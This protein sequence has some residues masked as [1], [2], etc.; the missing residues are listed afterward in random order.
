MT[1]TADVLIIG[2]GVHGAS[3]AFHLAGRGLRACILERR[4]PAAGA[5]GRSSGLVR[6]H[7]DLEPETRLAWESFQY[8]RDWDVRVGGECGFTRT[9][10]LHIPRPR[11]VEQMKAN[12]AMHQR[13]GIPSLVVNAD[14]V[15]RLAPSFYVDD[16]LAAAYEPESGHADPY[17]TTSS[18]LAAARA[19]GATL[20]QDCEV[21]GIL[22]EGG[23]V[24]GAQTT[25]GKFHAPVVVNAAGPWARR[26]AALAGLDLPVDTWR[27]DTLFIQRPPELRLP[28]PTVIDDAHEMYFRPETGGLTLVGLE[29]GNPLGEDP[30]GFTDKAKPGFVERAIERICLRIPA[31]EGGRLHSAH[32]GYDGISPDQRA[33]LGPAGPQGFFLQ[34]GMSGTG[35]KIAPAVGLC[36]AE[37]IVDGAPATVD[38]TPFG[39]ARLEEGG[40]LKGEHSYDKIWH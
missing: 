7:Y 37:W 30:D 19:G 29:D 15:A 25:Q 32:G 10:F 13:V 39:F 28:H 31:M 17:A 26:V 14:D 18:L 2:G 24:T 35:F 34:C 5:T 21:T 16:I 3:L 8:F 20:I 12:V 40:M 4:S 9:G 33:I 1:Q 38:I 27:H 11:Y 6:M 23:R 36:M 22:M